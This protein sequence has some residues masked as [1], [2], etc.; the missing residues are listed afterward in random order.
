MKN[1][2][3]CME[4]LIAYSYQTLLTIDRSNNVKNAGLFIAYDLKNI[5]LNEHDP[6]NL[7]EE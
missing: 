7:K 2:Y 6:V 5:T 1:T 3:F 4:T